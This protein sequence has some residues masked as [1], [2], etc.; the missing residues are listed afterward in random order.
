MEKLNRKADQ[1]MAIYVRAQQCIKLYAWRQICE[2]RS[3]T[4]KADGSCL[5]RLLKKRIFENGVENGC[6]R[7]HFSSAV[8]YSSCFC[9]TVCSWKCASSRLHENRFQ[10]IGTG[11]RIRLKLVLSSACRLLLRAVA[12]RWPPVSLTA[13]AN[14]GHDVHG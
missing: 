3:R 4:L 8:E 14:R 13:A 7:M 12:T 10:D 5:P 11:A 2:C 9:V 1:P 6:V